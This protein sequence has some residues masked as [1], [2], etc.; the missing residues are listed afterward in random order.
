MYHHRGNHPA[1]S[2]YKLDEWSVATPW[3]L[4]RLWPFARLSGLRSGS[5]ALGEVFSLSGPYSGSLI[6]G[7]ALLSL[8][9]LSGPWPGSLVLGQALWSLARL[10]F[11]ATR[12]ILYNLSHFFS[13][14]VT[15][16]AAQ[17]CHSL[18]MTGLCLWRR[19]LLPHEADDHQLHAREVR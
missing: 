10:R 19:W 14:K 11:S 13:C 3:S 7:Q 4:A 17:E 6:L 8:V 2:S 18:V 16:G 15:T 5:L 9:R 12:L 1:P